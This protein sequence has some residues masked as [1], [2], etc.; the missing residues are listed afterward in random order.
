VSLWTIALFAALALAGGAAVATQGVANAALGTRIG[1]PA[2]L[3]ASTTIVWLFTL[4]WYAGR[5]FGALHAPG[6]PPIHYVGGLCGFVIITAAALAMPRIGAALALSLFLVG[7][8]VAALLIEHHGW[9]HVPRVA[10][11]W[12][13]I[14]GIALI[15]G[16]ALLLRR[17]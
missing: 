2:A 14:A 17:R 7:Q 15:V 11:S 13:R 3:F 6:I 1:L 8:L 16:G 9:F 10:V 5:G 4:S 12:Q